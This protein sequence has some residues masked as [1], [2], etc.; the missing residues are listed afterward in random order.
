MDPIPVAPKKSG[1][2]ATC[3]LSTRIDSRQASKIFAATVT[4]L[5]RNGHSLASIFTIWMPFLWSQHTRETQM[6]NL[7]CALCTQ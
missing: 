7:T 3:I 1:A 2:D 6:S 5:Q 4:I